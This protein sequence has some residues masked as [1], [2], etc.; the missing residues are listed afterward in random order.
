MIHHRM[1]QID[2]KLL[3]Y[4]IILTTCELNEFHPKCCSEICRDVLPLLVDLTW[5]LIGL[6]ED[7]RRFIPEML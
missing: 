1:H 2:E 6:Q 4:T 3:Q 7:D 5:V